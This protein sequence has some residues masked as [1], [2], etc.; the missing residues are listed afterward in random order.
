MGGSALFKTRDGRPYLEA[1]HTRRLSDGG[2]DHPRWIA[3]VCPNCHRRAHYAD[4]SGAFNQR[5]SDRIGDLEERFGHDVG[6]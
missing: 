4:D 1:H 2:P 6:S 3:G 5:L